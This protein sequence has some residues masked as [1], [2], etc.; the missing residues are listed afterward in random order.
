LRFDFDQ[1]KIDYNLVGNLGESGAILDEQTTMV[2][3]REKWL[4]LQGL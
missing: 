2:R 1:E 3:K 4:I